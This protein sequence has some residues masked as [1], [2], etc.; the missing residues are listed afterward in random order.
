MIP[1][2]CKHLAEV[3]FPIVV[4]SKHSAREKS[5]RHGHPS[6]LHLWWAQRPLAACRAMLLGLLLPDPRDEQCPEDFKQE[7]RK[8]LRT[9]YASLESDDDLQRVFLR[10]IGEFANWDLSADPGYLK[11]ARG[12][13]LPKLRTGSDLR[14]G[15]DLTASLDADAALA[16]QQELRQILGDLNLTGQVRVEVI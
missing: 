10:F 7:A 3:D 15:L 4:V 16:L 14:V 2:D 8:L 6:T 9:V 1:K 12:Q 13:L 5:I 11:A